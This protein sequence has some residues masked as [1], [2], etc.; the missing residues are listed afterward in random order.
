M[1]A[2]K[3][4]EIIFTAAS[5]HKVKPRQFF[6]ILY[7]IILGTDR[8]PRAGSLVCALGVEQVRKMIEEVL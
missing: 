6:G 3:I 7:T 5:T 4:Q 1:D 8:G 2:E